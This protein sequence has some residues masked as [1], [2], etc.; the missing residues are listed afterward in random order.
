MKKYRWQLLILLNWYCGWY[1]PDPR[2]NA[3]DL[4]KVDSLTG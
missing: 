1:A 4:E 2:K 3:V